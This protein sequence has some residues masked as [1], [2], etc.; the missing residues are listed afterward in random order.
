MALTLA[1]KQRSRAPGDQMH[2]C[3]TTSVHSPDL[4]VL[5][6]QKLNT[7]RR[8]EHEEMIGNA[9]ISLMRRSVQTTFLITRV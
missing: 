3:H 7:P 8:L 5:H 9:E 1:V 6:N 2:C 4:I